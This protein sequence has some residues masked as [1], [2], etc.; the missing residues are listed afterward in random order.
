MTK[1]KLFAILRKMNNPNTTTDPYRGRRREVL[2]AAAYLYRTAS[3]ADGELDFEAPASRVNPVIGVGEKR[4]EEEVRAEELTSSAR[5]L[6]CTALDLDRFH[7]ASG[8]RKVVPAVELAG[9]ALT[10][11]LETA[12]MARSGVLEELRTLDLP[13]QVRSLGEDLR[14]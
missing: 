9:R 14:G 5:A 11:P 8:L 10:A 7:R 1:H 3:R 6:A 4:I 12:R 13:G 2:R